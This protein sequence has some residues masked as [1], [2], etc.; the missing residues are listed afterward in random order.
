MRKIKAF[1]CNQMAEQVRIDNER[2]GSGGTH[3]LK[4]YYVQTHFMKNK[5]QRTRMS[6]DSPGKHS[7]IMNNQPP[8]FLKILSRH[9]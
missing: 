8:L 2:L 3:L 4:T 6:L 5:S 7:N 1:P 9:S